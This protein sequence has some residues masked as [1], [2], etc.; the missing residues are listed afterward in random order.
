MKVLHQIGRNIHGFIHDMAATHNAD[1]VESFDVIW[2]RVC[3]DIFSMVDYAIRS[4]Y[5]C[6][7]IHSFDSLHHQMMTIKG[8]LHM[9]FVYSTL[10]H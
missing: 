5:S 6:R 1:F 8:T 7:K 10:M 3:R 2:E 9:I 4:E